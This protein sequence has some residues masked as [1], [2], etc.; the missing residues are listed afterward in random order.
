MN[1]VGSVIWGKAPLIG[2]WTASTKVQPAVAP[3]LSSEPQLSAVGAA[4]AAHAS[5][6]V[7]DPPF[8]SYVQPL[9]AVQSPGSCA[10][11]TSIAVHAAGPGVCVQVAIHES[12]AMW[13]P[14]EHDEPPLAH[15]GTVLPSTV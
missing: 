3:E 15:T 9:A 1:V 5:A 13:A 11:A 12:Q 4:T 2:M 8:A 10:L 6:H 14:S 7:G